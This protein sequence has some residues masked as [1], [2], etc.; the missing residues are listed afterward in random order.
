MFLNLLEHTGAKDVVLP[1][2]NKNPKL[3]QLLRFCSVERFEFSPEANSTTQRTIGSM[4]KPL[5]ETFL[6]E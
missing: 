5:K 3:Q 4:L 6:C 2:C 1:P